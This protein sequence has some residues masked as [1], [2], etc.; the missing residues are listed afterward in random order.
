MNGAVAAVVDD[1]EWSQYDTSPIVESSHTIVD[2][3]P[4]HWSVFGTA[5]MRIYVKE[6]RRTHRIVKTWSDSVDWD[7]DVAVAVVVVVVENPLIIP[8][9]AMLVTNH[10]ILRC[11][12]DVSS[13][14]HLN[15]H[16]HRRRS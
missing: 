10:D 9:A 7:D 2:M 8:Y 11:V 15:H 16:H 14:N 12:A 13:M 3:S 4:L 6:Y 1:K 5:N